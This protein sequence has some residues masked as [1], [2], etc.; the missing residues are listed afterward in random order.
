MLSDSFIDS[1]VVHK[2]LIL[3][4]TIASAAGPAAV[5]AP[6]FVLK[7]HILAAPPLSSRTRSD[8]SLLFTEKFCL[9]NRETFITLANAWLRNRQ[10]FGVCKWSCED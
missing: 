5:A 4:K 10:S 8:I 6:E 3:L 7:P 1:F 9:I 2:G